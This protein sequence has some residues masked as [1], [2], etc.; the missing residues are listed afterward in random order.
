MP[1]FKYRPSRSRYR[2]ISHFLLVGNTIWENRSPVSFVEKSGRYLKYRPINR[3]ISDNKSP[4]I[5]PDMKWLIYYMT[6]CKCK[7]FFYR[8]CMHIIPFYLVD[9]IYDTKS[10][11][12]YQY[13]IIYSVQ[14]ERLICAHILDISPD[15]RYLIWKTPSDMIPITDI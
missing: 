3:P 4:E 7:L 11:F 8:L 5:S 2:P 15:I 9:D 1:C 10:T 14:D 6:A 12:I 13:L